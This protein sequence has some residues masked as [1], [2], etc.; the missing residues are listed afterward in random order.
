MSAVYTA[1]L[2]E[3]KTSLDHRASE[4]LKDEVLPDRHPWSE[5]SER[6]DGLDLGLA[7]QHRQYRVRALAPGGGGS[8]IPLLTAL[9]MDGAPDEAPAQLETDGPWKGHKPLWWGCL[10]PSFSYTVC[11]L[12]RDITFRSGGMLLCYCS[13]S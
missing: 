11:T 2:I 9:T 12:P 1:V 10:P 8:T 7:V 3:L 5:R 13:D 4:D 6:S